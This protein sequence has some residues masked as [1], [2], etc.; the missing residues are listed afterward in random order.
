MKILLNKTYKKLLKL[1]YLDHLTGCFNRNWLN[2]YREAYNITG[3]F[4][5]IIDID[6]LKKCND[7]SGHTSGDILLVTIATHLLSITKNVV[8][9]GGDEFLLI[10]TFNPIQLLYHIDRISFGVG[11]VQLNMK[12]NLRTAMIIADKNMYN[13][14]KNKKH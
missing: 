5:S 1:A 7:T 2:K 11:V 4:I 14:K 12:F 8:R 9:L 13:M 10:T 6:D 3:T